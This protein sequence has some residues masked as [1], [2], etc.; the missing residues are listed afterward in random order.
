MKLTFLFI[1][2]VILGL[3][4]RKAN[5]GITLGYSPVAQIATHEFIDAI[6]A[7]NREKMDVAYERIQQILR[8]MPD[9]TRNNESIDEYMVL[10]AK[11]R[12]MA[13]ESK[14]MIVDE[15]DLDELIHLSGSYGAVVMAQ[16]TTTR[17]S[18]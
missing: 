17:E 1:L 7:K 5:A 10:L 14:E 9:A 12:Q 4:C 11:L 15:S 8:D 13:D 16:M 2:F 6:R 3:L 18:K